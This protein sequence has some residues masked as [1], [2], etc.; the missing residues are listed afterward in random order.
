MS[1]D[2]GMNMKPGINYCAPVGT[3]GFRGVSQKG[4]ARLIPLSD[5]SNCDAEM[6][7]FFGVDVPANLL[8]YLP[9]MGPDSA[10]KREGSWHHFA[11]VR[12]IFIVHLTPKNE[13]NSRF[14]RVHVLQA[15]LF[16]GEETPRVFCDARDKC[17]SE[18]RL[19]QEDLQTIQA[20]LE[21]KQIVLL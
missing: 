15:V 6:F 5:P 4:L 3:L 10:F 11:I 1:G 14:E 12:G 17:L 9:E 2:L 16:E 18:G 20:L 8:P 13:E 19:T 7:F 21:A